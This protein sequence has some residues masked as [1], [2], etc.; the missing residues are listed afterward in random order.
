MVKYLRKVS[1]V[2]FK[3]LAKDQWENHKEAAVHYANLKA[4]VD[5]YYNENS[6]HK[7]QTDKLVE[8]SMSS[9]EKS[10][11]TIY[12]LYKGLNVITELLKNINTTIKDDPAANQKINK[13]IETFAKISSNVTK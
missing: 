5:D 3:R 9:L 8:A 1:R 11:T 7:D 4:Y 6:A 10:S 12:D 2:L 13:A